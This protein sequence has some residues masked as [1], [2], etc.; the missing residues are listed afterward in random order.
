MLSPTNKLSHYKLGSQLPHPFNFAANPPFSC[1]RSRAAF[2]VCAILAALHALAR[3]ECALLTTPV[4]RKP[5]VEQNTNLLVL[6]TANSRHPAT[7]HSLRPPLCSTQCVL[8]S[9]ITCFLQPFAW[10]PTNVSRASYTFGNLLLPATSIDI[11]C[12]LIISHCVRPLVKGWTYFALNVT[13]HLL[14]SFV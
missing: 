10:H 11:S 12:I 2:L 13:H 9:G 7:S 6:P 5:C 3:Q 1:T 8:L 4:H 14:Q